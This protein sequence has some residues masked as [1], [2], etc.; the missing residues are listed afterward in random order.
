VR[1]GAW[2]VAFVRYMAIRAGV[3]RDARLGIVVKMEPHVRTIHS[4]RLV[5]LLLGQTHVGFDRAIVAAE[6]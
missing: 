3:G 4:E 5:R 1:L 6:P 2:A